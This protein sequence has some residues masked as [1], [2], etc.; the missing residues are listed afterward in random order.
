MSNIKNI[1]L[2]KNYEKK[3]INVRNNVLMCTKT[4]KFAGKPA[5]ITIIDKHAFTDTGIELKREMKKITYSAF[6][7]KLHCCILIYFF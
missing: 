4:F 2:Y 6:G 7:Q 1:S 5:Y 3:I